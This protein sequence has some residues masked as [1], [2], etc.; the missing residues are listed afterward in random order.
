MSS[1]TADEDGL[2]GEN[3]CYEIISYSA[4]VYVP[5]VAGFPLAWPYRYMVRHLVSPLTVVGPSKL[6]S[7]YQVDHSESLPT[8]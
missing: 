2:A 3:G 5:F 6:C 4:L 1:Y 8:A 7:P